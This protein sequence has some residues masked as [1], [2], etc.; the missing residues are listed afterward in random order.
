M[1]RVFIKAKNIVCV[2]LLGPLL[3]ASLIAGCVSSR[4]LQVAV[5]SDY[6]PFCVREPSGQAWQGRGG[7]DVILLQ[8]MAKDL[9]W[10][11]RPVN[12]EWP[13]LTNL[14]KQG[15]ADLAACGITARRDR[16]YDMIFTRPYATSGAVAVIPQDAVR[17]FPDLKALDAPG[18][19]L[20]VN[21]GGHLEKVARR[22]FERASILTV[23]NNLSLRD[24]LTLG[25]ADAVISDIYESSR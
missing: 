14:M 4:P 13:D 5:T 7:F 21:A 1:S 8:R 12:F 20:V 15:S 2:S 24:Q 16:A 23:A 11:L 3:L 9:G 6:P 22:R 18:I 17:Q 10:T 19:R 25:R